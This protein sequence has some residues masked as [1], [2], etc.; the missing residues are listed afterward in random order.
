MEIF[1]S[2]SCERGGFLGPQKKTYFREGHKCTSLYPD[3]YPFHH[4]TTTPIL[5]LEKLQIRKYHRN[6]HLFYV[7]LRKFSIASL[8]YN[9][10]SHFRFDQCAFYAPTSVGVYQV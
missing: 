3:F 10:Y 6:F 9:T 8:K 7:F 2:S 1:L 4:L 5:H